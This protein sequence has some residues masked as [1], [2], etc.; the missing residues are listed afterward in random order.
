MTYVITIITW[1]LLDQISKWII[2]ANFYGHPSKV[3]I[4]NIL[5]ITYTT[6]TGGAFG[7][8][9]HHPQFFVILSSMLVL[10]GLIMIPQVFRLSR[11]YQ[12]T[13]GSIIGGAAGNLVDRIRVGSVIDFINLH[14][15]PIFNVADIAI[16]VGVFILFFQVYKSMPVIDL[17]SIPEENE[18]PEINLQEEKEVSTQPD[19][20]SIHDERPEGI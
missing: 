2:T 14:F 11:L 7:L 5:S 9:S 8:F 3:V 18:E 1:L 10:A 13:I 17:N 16:C 20:E 19:E 12:F 15:W 6:N 4:E